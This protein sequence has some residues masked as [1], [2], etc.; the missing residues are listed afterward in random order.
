MLSL[1]GKKQGTPVSEPQEK[2]SWVGRLRAGLQKSSSQITGG[3][4]KIFTTRR[5]DQ[6][7][8]DELEELLIMADLGPELAAELTRNFGKEKF[9][10]DVTNEEVRAELSARIAEILSGCAK[11]LA[12]D[13]A[14]KPFVIL[15]V[16]VNGAGKTTTIGTLAQQYVAVG[17]KVMLAAGDTFRAAAIEQLQVWG[18]RAGVPV[19][20][21]TQGADSA[22]VAHEAMSAAHTANA[23]VLLMDTAGRLHNK[24]DL[25]AELQ[26]L[27]RVIKKLDESAPHAV[28]LVLDATTGQNAVSQTKTFGELV[29]VTGLIVTKL[30]GTAKAGVVVALARQFGLPIHAIGVGET[31]ADL[32][33]FDANAFAKSLLGMDNAA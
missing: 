12:I 18:D 14:K 9:G 6:A 29:D 28:L 17:H 25:M 27:V 5:L 33:A 19:V 15:V 16:G 20:A 2:I 11:P 24:S 10:K 3:I 22:A 7:A 8:L 31:A 4:T 23:D 30:D 26:K 1:F 21:K 32:S 13:G